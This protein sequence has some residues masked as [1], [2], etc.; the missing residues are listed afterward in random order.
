M[1]KVR[2]GSHGLK[3]N[4]GGFRFKG[5]VTGANKEDVFK[6]TTQKNNLN[7]NTLKF[8]VKTSEDNEVYVR[9]SDSE[10]EKAWFYKRGDKKKGIDGESK[11]VDWD[12]RL[13]FH[14]EG[15]QAIGV[16][17][18]LDKDEEEK[19]VIVNK[20]DFDAAE[21]VSERISDDLPVRIIGDI[22]F[23]S[24]DGQ[25]GKIR[26]K[27][28]NIKKIYNSFVDFEKDDFVEE[29]YFKQT[30]LYMGIDRA[31]G[32][33]GKPDTEDPRF[34]VKGKVITYSTLEDVEFVI[35][36]KK[37]GQN[38]QKNLKPYNCIEVHGN[39]N[40]KRIAE[41]VE[42]SGDDW[43]GEAN[44]F[45]V[46]NNP[47][48]FEFEITGINTKNIDKETYTEKIV[49]DAFKADEEFGDEW[50]GNEEDKSSKDEENQDGYEW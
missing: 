14:D 28:L 35:R 20:H 39:I 31:N 47:R 3:L 10:K 44:P 5:L 27:N 15:F 36:N 22:E 1:A 38:F 8:G 29:N 34:L 41:E 46:V 50:D 2:L 21:Y 40:N 19:N 32:K 17:I 37:L 11:S 6:T 33:D 4:E 43:G 18:G 24:F 42:D 12:S 45:E 13:N 49:A 25:D 48:K 16:S 9:L 23:S 26:S 7:R 30:F